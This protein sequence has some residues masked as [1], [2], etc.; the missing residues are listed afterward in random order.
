MALGQAKY[1]STLD[2]ASSFWHVPAKNQDREKTSFITPLGLFK[3]NC[4][5]FG[6]CN[7]ISSF[8]RLVK[9]CPGD[10][11]FETMLVYLDN[12]IIFPKTFE[13]HAKHLDWVFTC[14]W[15]EAQA[16]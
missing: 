6:L 14:L 5:T 4:T 3:F 10:F 16:Q 12:I 9:R 2:L 7:A 13:D 1:F 15:A 8:Q 11:N